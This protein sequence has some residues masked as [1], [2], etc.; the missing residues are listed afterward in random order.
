M[1][2]PPQGLLRH[3]CLQRWHEPFQRH[4][5][6]NGQA[7]MVKP[8][9][10]RAVPW[11]GVG[12]AGSDREPSQAMT[13]QGTHGPVDRWQT[14]LPWA[15]YRQDSWPHLW[16]PIPGVWM[17]AGNLCL[18]APTPQNPS[19]LRHIHFVSRPSWDPVGS[20]A[21]SWSEAV[22]LW[23][24]LGDDNSETNTVGLQFWK[25]M[26]KLNHHPRTFL[27]A[28]A[29]CMSSGARDQACA[30]AVTAPGPQ[31]AEPAGNSLRKNFFFI[32]VD[33]QC[34]VDF[35]CKYTEFLCGKAAKTSIG[36]ECLRNIKFWIKRCSTLNCS[37]V[38]VPLSACCLS[39]RANHHKSLEMK[40]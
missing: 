36:L 24:V 10:D 34:S 31:P 16:R 4:V 6:P 2:L 32:P 17:G 12:D 22:P 9:S 7:D 11:D 40:I 8:R 18:Y 13:F 27:A 29:A 26:W 28:P 35:C 38:F 37:S 39:S 1:I 5:H 21:W 3:L 23:R 19:T 25:I 20:G 33:L 14:W 30:T 15:A